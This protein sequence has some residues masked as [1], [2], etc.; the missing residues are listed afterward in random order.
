MQHLS[1]ALSLVNSAALRHETWAPF[2]N[3]RMKTVEEVRRDRLE[4]LVDEFGSLAALNERLGNDR[5]DSTL[6]QYRNKS[7]N[8][9]GGAPKVMGSDVARRLEDACKKERGWMDTDPA[10]WPFPMIDHAKVMQLTPD[11]RSQVQF[12]LL[13]AATVAGIELQKRAEAA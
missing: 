12:G 8:S 10:L 2:C 1:S 11:Q 6:S 9:K 13:T 3:R 5:R 4:L 7:D